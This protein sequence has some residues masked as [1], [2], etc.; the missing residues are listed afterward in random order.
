[1]ALTESDMKAE[2]FYIATF[3]KR[4]LNVRFWAKPEEPKINVTEPG[5]IVRYHRDSAL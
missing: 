2:I 3:L 4:N 5:T 1:M